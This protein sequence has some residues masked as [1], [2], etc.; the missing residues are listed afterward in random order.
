[1]LSKEER[2]IAVRYSPRGM[3]VWNL[4][5]IIV[6]TFIVCE[7]NLK[8][9]PQ[10]VS[11]QDICERIKHMDMAQTAEQSPEKSTQKASH[12]VPIERR[13]LGRRMQF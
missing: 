6:S 3:R 1:M 7:T 10:E 9:T 4:P 13:S 12:Q 5:N 2:P 8:T 11:D